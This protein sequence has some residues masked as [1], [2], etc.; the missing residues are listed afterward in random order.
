MALTAEPTTE[1]T[2]DL[3][4]AYEDSRQLNARHGRTYYLATLL[5]PA[6]K[7][8]S[9][10]ALYGYARA[11]DEVVDDLASTDSPAVKR[12]RLA[13]LDTTPV[14]LALADTLR[15]WDIPR[16]HVDD[17]LDSMLADLTTTGYDTWA[18]LTGYVH[19]SAC[20]IGLQMLPILGTVV[21]A[22]VA[23]PYARDLGTAFQLTNFLRDVGEDLARGRVYL[24]A[25]DLER[26]GV[27]RAD[28]AG[29]EPTEGVRRLLAFEISRARALYADAWHGIRLLDPTSR[30]CVQT[31]WTLYGGIL[32]AIERSGYRVLDRR[33]SVSP[34]RRAAVAGPG[35]VR[36]LAA[37][38]GARA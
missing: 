34:V 3:T 8:P 21:P 25:E 26:F 9:V 1:P 19:G 20:V 11:A 30:P 6:W 18:D 2:G 36:A 14:G 32:E 13:S 33:V 10:H 27:T 23:A 38:R 29:P 17:F 22:A 7:R 4:G 15:R 12:A 24:P 35:L 37:R 16:S 5:L 28:L 31:A